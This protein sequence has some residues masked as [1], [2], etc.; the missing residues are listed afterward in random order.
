[1]ITAAGGGVAAY[2][3]WR[4]AAGFMPEEWKPAWSA[5]LLT[6]WPLAL[7]MLWERLQVPHLGA[8]LLGV[9]AG[10]FVWMSLWLPSIT[11]N[12]R[13]RLKALRWAVPAGFFLAFLWEISSG[14]YDYLEFIVIGQAGAAMLVIISPL[15]AGF[16]AATGS[17][18]CIVLASISFGAS[19]TLHAPHCGHLGG[20]ELF[21]CVVSGYDI[22]ENDNSGWWFE[23]EGSLRRIMV[24]G[25]ER[26]AVVAEA[27]AE[28]NFIFDGAESPSSFHVGMLKEAWGKPGDGVRFEVFFQSGGRWRKAGEKYIDPKHRRRERAWIDVPVR[29]ESGEYAKWKVKLHPGPQISAPFSRDPDARSDWGVVSPQIE[30][31]GN[32]GS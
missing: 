2:A 16:G 1:M 12:Y 6:L 10:G 8:W 30:S 9:C 15:T 29:V 25:V 13:T 18:L 31:D 19:W 32:A 20:S 26:R 22:V 11:K 3:V 4:Y 7:M 21:G 27:P 5:G 24:G 23:G 28:L 14:R 17:V